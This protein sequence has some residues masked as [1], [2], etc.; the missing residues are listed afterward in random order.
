[1]AEDGT[2]ENR[3]DLDSTKLDDLL[4]EEL[5][6]GDAALARTE[7]KTGILLAV[8]SPILT[9][10]VAVLPR[11]STPLAAALGFWAAL[12]LLGVALLLLLVSVRPR[13]RG[14]GFAVYQSMTDVELAA[15]FTR[16]AADPT[17]WHRE[18]LRVVS[19]LGAKK[20]KLLRAAT[21]ILVLAL[22]FAIVAAIAATIST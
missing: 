12:L 2:I 20:F 4:K 18:R 13:L 16:I 5:S 10:G 21:T 9:V 7:T 22:L 8:F 19:R 15:H 1:M 11:L 3:R 14:S 6:R 17:A